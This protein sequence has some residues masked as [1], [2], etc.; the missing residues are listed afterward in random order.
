MA[1]RTLS[2]Q[3]LT[4][5]VSFVND[6]QCQGANETQHIDIFYLLE[7]AHSCQRRTKTLGPRVHGL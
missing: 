7:N 5:G 2:S 1:T 6:R 3:H 4:F